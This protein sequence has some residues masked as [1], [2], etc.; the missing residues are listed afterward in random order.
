VPSV[1]V[2]LMCQV[3]EP[4]WYVSGGVL[5]EQWPSVRFQVLVRGQV[6]QHSCAD[7]WEL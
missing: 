6:C 5:G 4:M 3:S 2:W 1:C 7:F